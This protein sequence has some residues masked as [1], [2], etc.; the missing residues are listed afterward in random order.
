MEFQDRGITG[1][2]DGVVAED[3]FIGLLVPHRRFVVL[4][5]KCFYEPP[6]L[7]D[8]WKYIA[9]IRWQDVQL[10]SIYG[11]LFEPRLK[12][13]KDILHVL[14]NKLSKSQGIW[15]LIIGIFA[16]TLRH[17]LT[18]LFKNKINMHYQTLG[19]VLSQGNSILSRITRS[20][21]AK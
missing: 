15:R 1:I 5:K 19:P 17:I 11:E 12:H 4:N 7:K 9:R 2:P 14:A 13:R 21:S 16:A 8:Y 6:V 10:A 20:N 18:F 3:F